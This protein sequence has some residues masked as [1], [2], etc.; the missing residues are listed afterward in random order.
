ML[1]AGR[2]QGGGAAVFGVVLLFVV[3]KKTRSETSPALD[4]IG[5]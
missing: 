3:R 1:M 2:K 5:G 4:E